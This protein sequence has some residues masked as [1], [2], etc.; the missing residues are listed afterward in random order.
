VT[1]V[2]TEFGR[3]GVAVCFDMR[4]TELYSEMGRAGA[5]IIVTPAA[6]NMTTGPAH[7]ELLIRARALDNQVFHAA[8][9]S[10][11]NTAS[12]YI[13]YGNSMVCDPWGTIIAK[14]DEKEGIQ[15]TEIDLDMVNSV[16][17]QIPVNHIL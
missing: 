10:A 4:F 6:F 7:W 14:A 13:A 16:R 5:R 12:N 17:R 15:I 8:V 3:I 11:R 1:V 9:S 2:E